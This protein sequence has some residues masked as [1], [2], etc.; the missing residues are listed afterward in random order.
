[1]TPGT[2]RTR[3]AGTAC[4]E[5]T[6]MN[7][8]RILVS[9]SL[10]ISLLGIAC[11]DP[12]VA[13]EPADS[14]DLAA[15][16]GVE[17]ASPVGITVTPDTG[18]RYVLDQIHGLYRLGEDGT[19]E[20]V[21][22]LAEFPEADVW[23]QSA[24]TDIAALGDG[25]FAITALADGYL[26]DIEAGTLMQHFCYEPGWEEWGE[27][28]QQLTTSLGYDPETNSIIAQPQTQ[29]V[30]MDGTT[31]L[32][33]AVGIYDASLGGDAPESW[34]ELSDSSFLAT[35]MAVESSESILLVEA[36]GTLH[37][38]TMDAA[39]PVRLGKLQTTQSVGGA[40]IDGNRFLVVDQGTD[41]LIEYAI[42]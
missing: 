13:L 38:Y 42:D 2:Q 18:E 5:R 32:G 4:A 21:L 34:Y 12:S 25:R 19:A 3:P 8:S 30:D 16:M 24:W 28:E 36:D 7:T 39:A 20:Q 29:L 23:P 17:D 10:S 9:A 15:A 26:L 37:R 27:T 40:A 22:S 41:Q 31:A 35:G 11:G 33:S 6:G 14:I 1:M